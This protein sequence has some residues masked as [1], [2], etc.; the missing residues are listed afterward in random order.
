MA[1]VSFCRAP[2]PHT[3]EPVRINAGAI[4]FVEAV[5]EHQVGQTLIQVFGQLEQGDSMVHI[6]TNNI[7]IVARN[8]PHAP[9][10]LDHH[11]QRPACSA[12]NGTF[13]DGVVKT[14]L[15]SLS[16]TRKG[17]P[18]NRRIGPPF[19]KT[20]HAL[21]PA[22]NRICMR[23]DSSAHRNRVSWKWKIYELDS[24]KFS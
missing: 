15:C 22:L 2:N 16:Y 13:T 4:L 18:W 3:I 19:S 9:I 5:S 12:G 6:Y 21:Q 8:T 1:I 7:A 23:I 14:P 11:L 10:F 17:R 20:S 24:A